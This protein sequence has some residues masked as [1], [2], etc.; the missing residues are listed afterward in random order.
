VLSR[1]TWIG[2]QN[3]TYRDRFLELNYPNDRI[4][5]TGNIKFDGATPDREHAEV[6]KRRAL[7]S[8]DTPS[9]DGERIV[10][11]CGSTQAP[12]ESLC[13]EAFASLLPRFPTLRMILV[14]RHAERF[15]EVARLV[16]SSGLPWLRRSQLTDAPA[17][18]HWRVLLADSVGELRWWWGLADLGFVGGSFGS[19]GGQNM[20]EPCAYGVATSFGPNTRNFTDVVQLLLDARA[21]VQFQEPSQLEPWVASMIEHPEERRELQERAKELAQ[22][23]RG[24]VQRTWSQLK[25]ILA[26]KD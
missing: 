5:V 13:L 18:T 24:A 21:A 8:L 20:I 3:A 25:A 14:P 19:R 2:A 12:E 1:V 15:D 23:Q 7:L 26:P 17:G 6:A 16:E 9:E 10:W 4:D 22:K 11:L